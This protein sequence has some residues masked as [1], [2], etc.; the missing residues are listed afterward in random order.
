MDVIPDW[1]YVPTS[2]RL[3]LPTY[4]TSQRCDS[5][6]SQQNSH[7]LNV[8]RG[9]FYNFN[10]ICCHRS[11]SL[12]QMMPVGQA[13][14]PPTRDL[15]ILNHHPWME[16]SPA[17]MMEESAAVSEAEALEEQMLR[18]GILASLQDAPDNPD[19]KVEVHKSSVSSLRLVII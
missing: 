16:P 19:A 6:H 4:T 7:S 15:S 13:A 10:L 11:G 1:A 9:R 14:A 12:S 18:A 5:S 3:R 2:A 17:W 8:H